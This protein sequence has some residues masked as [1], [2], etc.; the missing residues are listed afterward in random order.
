MKQIINIIVGCLVG[1]CICV[2][3]TG[4]VTNGDAY[5]FDKFETFQWIVWGAWH[6]L[7]ILVGGRVGAED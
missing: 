4:L 5:D 6:T 1:F 3:L 2:L 7:F